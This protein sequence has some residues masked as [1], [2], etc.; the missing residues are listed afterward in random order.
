MLGGVLRHEAHTEAGLADLDHG[1]FD[2]VHMDACIKCDLPKSIMILETRRQTTSF[3]TKTG[4]IAQ[5][6]PKILWPFTYSLLLR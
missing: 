5:G 6:L 2:S 4:M 3:P 1:V